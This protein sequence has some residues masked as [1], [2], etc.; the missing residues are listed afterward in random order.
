MQKFL[1]NFAVIALA[2]STAFLTSCTDD[3]D[4]MGGTN[5]LPPLVRFETEAG[6]LSGDADL[7]VGESFSVKVNAQ[8]GDAQLK[9]ISVAQDGSTS[10]LNG[11]LSIIKPDG[12]TDTNNPLLI[13]GTAKDGATYEIT[14]APD[15]TEEVGT[16]RTYTFT[17][18]DE[19]DLTDEVSLIITS[20]APPGTPLDETLTGVLLNQAG[21]TGT[22]GLDLDNGNGTGSSDADAEI[23]DLGIDCTINPDNAENWRAQFGT[24]NGADM[25]RVDKSQLENFEFA[26][27]D[28]KE[29]IE[30][31]YNTGTGLSNGV[32]QDPSCNETT[33]TDV[34]GTVAVDDLFVVFANSTYYL[35]KVDAINAIGG[36]NGDNIEFSIKY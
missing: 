7:I 35:I 13:I 36:S 12:G 9:T 5:D 30:E 17:V 3:E 19:N 10:A 16:T 14:I 33:V 24:I 20:V 2:L 4:P 11:R 23:R 28:T 31:A 1:L 26:T 18:A 21:P 6:F 25:V 15:G 32:S 29:A 22:G 34:T 8:I 27:V